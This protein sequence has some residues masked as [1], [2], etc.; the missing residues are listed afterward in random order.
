MT[1]FLDAKLTIHQLCVF[2]AIEINEAKSLGN[3]FALPELT[4]QFE[5]NLQE[6]RKVYFLPLLFLNIKKIYKISRV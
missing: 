2:L 5:R 6:V 4:Q 1:S 3:T